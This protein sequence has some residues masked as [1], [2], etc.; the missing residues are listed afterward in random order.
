MIYSTVE[1]VTLAV[2][3]AFILHLFPHS[4]LHRRIVLIVSSIIFFLWATPLSFFILAA[5]V[6]LLFLGMNICLRYENFRKHKAVVYFLIGIVLVGNLIC[7][8]YLG[9]IYTEIGLSTDNPII[10]LTYSHGL[11]LGISFYTLQGIAYLVDEKRGVAKPENISSTFLYMIFFGQLIA[12]PIVRYKEFMPQVKKLALA[13]SKDIRIGALLISSGVFKKLFIGDR[14]GQYADQIFSD[15]MGADF[16]ITTL[17]ILLF[18]VQIWGDFSGYTDMGRGAARL[19]G[20]HLPEN[21]LS[22]YLS[23]TPSEFWR[24]WHVT[25]S[26]WIRDYIY[27]S[28]GGSKINILVTS[29]NLLLC[30]IIGGFWHGAAWTFAI[31]GMYHGALLAIWR[32]GDFLAPK[33]MLL[34][35]SPI[36]MFPFIVFGWLLFRAESLE[37]ISHYFVTITRIDSAAFVAS[38]QTNLRLTLIT[39][40]LLILTFAVQYAHKH[41]KEQIVAF[42]ARSNTQTGLIVGSTWAFSIFFMGTGAPFIYFNF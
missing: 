22:P 12:G 20:I 16:L 14:A 9:W 35:K 1:F 17:A 39:M 27:I 32:L 33:F 3:T 37:Q 18:T 36:V 28:F 8:K 34:I 21:F 30:M 2:V 6:L 41:F 31:W 25:L 42:A 19:C 4:P 13:K 24:R 38:L 10:L 11:P 7:W 29:F 23:K 15:F 5:S 26:H 40:I